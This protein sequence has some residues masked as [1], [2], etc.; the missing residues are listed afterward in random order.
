MLFKKGESLLASGIINSPQIIS[1][2]DKPST[3]IGLLS[4]FDNF[5]TLDSLNPYSLKTSEVREF[6]GKMGVKIGPD[7]VSRK[8]P[9]L[10]RLIVSIRNTLKKKSS[11]WEWDCYRTMILLLVFNEDG[12]ILNFQFMTMFNFFWMGIY[13]SVGD[14]LSILNPILG[15]LVCRETKRQ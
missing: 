7:H 11:V 13:F 1:P 4:T 9:K 2:L 14:N 10:Y 15:L 5:S 12:R 3:E 8:P 6:H